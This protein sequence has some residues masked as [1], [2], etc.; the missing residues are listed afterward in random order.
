[1]SAH[2]FYFPGEL[3]GLIKLKDSESKHAHV[4]RVGQGE[5]VQLFN[6]RGTVADCVIKSAS[7]RELLVEVLHTSTH[8]HPPAR[9]ILA[10]AASKAVRRGFFMEKAAELGA[11]EIWV[12]EAER[13]VGKL[14][15]CVIDSCKQQLI[16]GGK[17]SRN[18]WFPAL[19]DCRNL[20][21]LLKKGAEANPEGKLLPWEGIGVHALISLG[22][23]GQPGTT[24]YVIGPE[25]GLAEKEVARLQEAGYQPVSL[26]ERVLRC[27][28]AAVLCLGLHMW[29]SQR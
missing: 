12:W 25:G 20:D 16:A 21:G 1:M 23:L 8:P 28:T 6:G 5:R 7:P 19:C 26:G 3:E 2:A 24:V 18:P 9:A 10:L 4:L 15:A 14:T 11:A 13:S 27:E 22:Q 17:Q 29:A